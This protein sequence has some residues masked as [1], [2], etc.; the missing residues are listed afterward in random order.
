MR[1]TYNTV[2]AGGQ[3]QEK[4]RRSITFPPMSS[5]STHLTVR[6]CALVHHPKSQHDGDV[7]GFW[8]PSP[9]RSA[10]ELPITTLKRV[11]CSSLFV[12]RPP[13]S[14]SLSMSRKWLVFA[15]G[16]QLLECTLSLL[17]ISR[18][19]ASPSRLGAKSNRTINQKKDEAA[20]SFYPPH[21]VRR[22][23]LLRQ[24]A[25][26]RLI[27]LARSPFLSSPLFLSLTFGY[28]F[29]L[30]RGFRLPFPFRSRSHISRSVNR[31][32]VSTAR[33]NSHIFAVFWFS[34]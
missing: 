5:S 30:C 24:T 7:C 15:N 23:H 16:S 32:V 1:R 19:S 11:L 9:L 33:S 14:R 12:W 20:V 2:R 6:A 34:T 3:R 21:M 10:L 17:R 27:Y 8:N 13:R 28:K 4:V 31:P 25:L 29:L 26:S 22:V 18:P